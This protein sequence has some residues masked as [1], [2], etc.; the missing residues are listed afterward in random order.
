[1]CVKLDRR[2]VKGDCPTGDT[3]EA[4]GKGCDCDEYPFAS[5]AQGGSQQSRIASVRRI[6]S[7]DNR[8]AGALLG[9]F[10]LRERVINDDKFF[11]DVSSN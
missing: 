10:F 2:P 6:T 1:M 4:P 5:S 8:K 11:V 3:D 9:S 7:G